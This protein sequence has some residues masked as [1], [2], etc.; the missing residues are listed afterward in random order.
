M[1]A[2]QQMLLAEAASVANTYATWNPSDKGV[3]ITLSGGDLTYTT[4]SAVQHVRST[5]SK[6]SGKWY[7]E[8]TPTTNGAFTQIGIDNGSGNVNTSLGVGAQCIAYDGY[9]AVFK[10][11]ITVATYASYS[12][13]DVIGVAF[14]CAT[15]NVTFYKN[16]T[17][18]GTPGSVTGSI[19]CA[20]GNI[21]DFVSV[22]VANFGATAMTYTAPS[23]YNQGVY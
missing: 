4:T 9:G 21:S 1:G 18:Q 20:A 11:G 5:L 12:T 19:Y 8:V 23:G 14:D 10:N 16:N 22:G 7:F 13:G 15:G 17:L 3:Y 2:I 6:A